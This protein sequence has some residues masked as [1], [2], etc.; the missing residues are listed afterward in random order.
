METHTHTHNWPI[1]TPLFWA[2][3]GA[4]SVQ[5]ECQRK[6][7]R[8]QNTGLRWGLTKKKKASSVFL[9]LP[10]R[11]EIGNWFRELRTQTGGATVYLRV[12]EV[13]H[14]L[15][16]EVQHLKHVVFRERACGGGDGVGDPKLLKHAPVPARRKPPPRLLWENSVGH[17]CRHAFASPLAQ[18]LSALVQRSPR[19]NE[20]VDDDDGLAL[21]VPVLDGH[22]PFL[23]VTHLAAGDDLDAEVVEHFPKPLSGAVVGEGHAVDSVQKHGRVQQRDARLQ[24]PNRVAVEVEA[25]L[26]RVQVVDQETRGLAAGRQVAE[27]L[28]VRIGGRDLA[29]FHRPFHGPHGIVRQHHHQLLDKRLQE[30]HH[31]LKLAQGHVVVVEAGQEEH[32]LPRNHVEGCETAHLNVVSPVGKFPP[33]SLVKMK[34]L[35]KLRLK[36]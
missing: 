20:V 29:F 31:H 19:L 21:W 9:Y 13:E 35:W 34:A 33:A 17:K 18:S 27:H 1:E 15:R 12:V 30:H 6:A 2:Q 10:V 23:S 3:Q 24:R 11:A 7:Q 5:A 25:V 22:R 28:G 36:I 8:T 16:E 4:G 26:E 32:A 14:D